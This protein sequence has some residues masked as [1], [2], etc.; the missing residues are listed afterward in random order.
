MRTVT[1]GRR[2]RSVQRYSDDCVPLI[3]N[4]LRNRDSIITIRG[5]PKC[6]LWRHY[7][8]L[9]GRMSLAC[10]KT[11]ALHGRSFTSDWP[12]FPV[13]PNTRLFVC[14][15]V[16]I[17]WHSQVIYLLRTKEVECF[18]FVS[19]IVNRTRTRRGSIISC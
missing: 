2:Q 12:A 3:L 15:F 8:S 1:V 7:Y 10:L 6:Y 19:L 14:L 9:R 5:S 18:E 11:P 4:P 17:C 16:L 13:L